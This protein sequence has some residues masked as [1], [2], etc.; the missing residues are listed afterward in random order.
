[1]GTS[2]DSARQQS[3]YNLPKFHESR[4]LRRLVEIAVRPQSCHFVAI[5]RRV[6]RGYGEYQRPRASSGFPH[7][8][9]DLRS[10]FSR[11]IDIENDQ[12]RTRHTGIDPGLLEQL[13]SLLAVAH[14]LDICVKFGLTDCPADEQNVSRVILNNQ[15]EGTA[16]AGLLRALIRRGDGNG[17][18][19]PRRV[20][21]R[22]RS[23]PRNVPRF[24]GKSPARYRSPRTARV[25]EGV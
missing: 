22:P 10:L 7:I 21:S 23:V 14:N 16:G 5:I 20:R 11:Q 13:D 2:D 8:L 19:T 25:Y 12:S 15:D 9:Q 17:K 1:M 6:R 18:W 24:A 4:N 3:F